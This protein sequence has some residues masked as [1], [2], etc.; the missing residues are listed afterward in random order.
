M[1]T[2]YECLLLF[3]LLVLVGFFVLFYFEVSCI[4]NSSKQSGNAFIS[5]SDPVAYA[6]Y[7]GGLEDYV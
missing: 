6:K 3:G 1:V 2:T 4:V 5:P 7:L